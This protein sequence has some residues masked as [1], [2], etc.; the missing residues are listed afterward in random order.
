M[1]NKNKQH[2][3][4]SPSK[5]S[6]ASN[7]RIDQMKMINDMIKR[8]VKRLENR[9]GDARPKS[10][11]KQ[12]ESSATSTGNTENNTSR[13]NVKSRYSV[14]QGAANNVTVENADLVGEI[15]N[16]GNL[17]RSSFHFNDNSEL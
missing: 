16:T 11:F 2:D 4:S 7:T 12:Q 5:P 8:D 17:F 9:R 3:E 10:D 13:K 1:D 14:D 15:L 6:A